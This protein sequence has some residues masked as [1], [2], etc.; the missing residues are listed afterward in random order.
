[1]EHAARR[2]G[3]SLKRFLRHETN[4]YLPGSYFTSSSYKTTLPVFFRIL[5]KAGWNFSPSLIVNG[6][7]SSSPISDLQN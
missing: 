6:L 2:T 5:R 4:C 3:K 7:F 1:M